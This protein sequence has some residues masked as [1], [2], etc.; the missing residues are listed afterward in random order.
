[1]DY[2]IFNTDEI[3]HQQCYRLL[4]GSIVPRPIAWVSSVDA[5]GVPNL[6]PFSFFSIVSHYPPLLSMAV[7][8]KTH[9]PKHT[10]ANIQTTKGFVV[11]TVTDDFAEAMNASS[12]N[13]EADQ[14]EFAEIGLETVP[15]DLVDA[16]RIKD[17]PV[18]M[19][20]TFEQVLKFGDEWV[21][22]LV[23]G[24]V[25]RWHVREDLMLDDKYVNPRT[26]HPVGRLGGPRYCRTHDIYEMQ[27]PYIQPDVAH[28]NT[29]VTG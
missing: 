5:A 6:A 16:P 22:D 4:I 10:S 14:D 20:C 12:A 24:R 26:L 18:A 29:P 7:S 19:E 11:H 13:Y 15:S 21:T 8:E 28:P 1:M 3:D 27:A 23:I 17:C 9:A 25:L 2:R